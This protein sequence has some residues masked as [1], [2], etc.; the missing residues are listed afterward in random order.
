[1]LDS[2]PLHVCMCMCVA[3]NTSLNTINQNELLTKLMVIFDAKG[4]DVPMRNYMNLYLV[5]AS[6]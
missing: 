4:G 1:M 5:I 6:S 3:V 2:P